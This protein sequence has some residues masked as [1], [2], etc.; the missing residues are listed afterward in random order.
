MVRIAELNFTEHDVTDQGSLALFV[1]NRSRCGIYWLDFEDGSSYVGQSV[2]ARTRLAT[3]R[4]R[5]NDAVVVRFAEC[6]L[7]RLDDLELATIQYVQKLRPLRNVLLTSR[8]AGHED[9][10]ITVREGASLALP[11]ERGRRG[12]LNADQSQSVTVGPANAAWVKLSSHDKYVD[13]VSVLSSLLS[14]SVP[15]PAQ[16]QEVL[17]TL[18]ALPSTNRSTGWRRLCTLSVGRLEVLRVFEERDAGTTSMHWYM[19]LHPEATEQQVG[20][21]LKVAGV[22]NAHVERVAYKALPD[23]VLTVSAVGLESLGAVLRDGYVLD[24]VYKLVVSLM[25]QGINPIRRNH[26]WSFAIDVLRDH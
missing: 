10:L 6:E 21:A 12:L 9:L 8:P 11:W 5:W 14:E 20:R 24:E 4:R 22:E 1:E 2:N 25:R 17:W 26:N 16:T 13:L 15:S 18:T 3:H 7:E 19:N 23:P